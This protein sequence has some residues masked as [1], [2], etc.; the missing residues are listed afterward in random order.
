[1]AQTYADDVPIRGISIKKCRKA[2]SFR[3]IALIFYRKSSDFFLNMSKLVLFTKVLL[4]LVFHN[5]MSLSV[6]E[7]MERSYLKGRTSAGGIRCQFR[8]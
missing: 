1:M 5:S 2:I 4:L 7:R 3:I 8:N 6:V